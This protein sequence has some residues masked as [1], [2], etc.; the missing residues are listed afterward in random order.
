ME[1]SCHERSDII[2]TKLSDLQFTKA[3]ISVV[4]TEIHLLDSLLVQEWKIIS[5]SLQFLSV[6]RCFDDVLLRHFKAS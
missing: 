3:N 1:L 2:H 4:V 5:F 6:E